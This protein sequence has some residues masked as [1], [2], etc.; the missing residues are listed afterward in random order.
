MRS[1]TTTCNATGQID[2]WYREVLSVWTQLILHLNRS[3][4]VSHIIAGTQAKASGPKCCWRVCFGLKQ[5][6]PFA[7]VCDSLPSAVALH[8]VSDFAGPGSFLRLQTSQHYNVV[9]VKVR[10]TPNASPSLPT[11]R[12]IC[13]KAILFSAVSTVM[14]DL[15]VASAATA[16]YAGPVA[17]AHQCLRLLSALQVVAQD[18]WCVI[19]GMHGQQPVLCWQC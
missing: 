4:S 8:N 15:L 11:L 16:I 12:L 5:L 17:S 10:Q 3:V 7:G 9:V 6:L 19:N 1:S 2:I 14:K 18:A 13:K